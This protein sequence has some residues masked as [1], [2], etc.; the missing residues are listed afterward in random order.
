[1]A[2]GRP[3]TEFGKEGLHHDELTV[4][5][6]PSS[7]RRSRREMAARAGP[8]AAQVLKRLHKAQI[9]LA[10]VA[11]RVHNEAHPDLVR[12]RQYC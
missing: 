1:M 9:N 4:L 3:A 2:P 12:Q 11:T 7:R 8:Q 6:R 10:M 5:E